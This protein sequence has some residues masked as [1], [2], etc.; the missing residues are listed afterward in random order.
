MTQKL[1]VFEIASA[2]KTSA[3]PAARLQSHST[4]P[5]FVAVKF[6]K[7]EINAQMCIGVC[8]TNFSQLSLKCVRQITTKFQNTLTNALSHERLT[9][10]NMII[11]G[12]ESIMKKLK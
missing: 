4:D 12:C 1:Q 7:I 6:F 2:Q 9:P 11:N 3:P 5:F 10:L 8:V